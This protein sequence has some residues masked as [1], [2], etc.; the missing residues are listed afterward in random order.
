MKYK[1]FVLKNSQGMELE[2]S[3]LGGIA[4]SLTAPDRDGVFEN[5]L[6]GF[7]DPTLCKAYGHVSTLVGRVCNRIRKGR[8]T[9][10]GKTYQLALNTES[11]GIK[12]SLHGGAIGFG[13]KV[14]DVRRFDSKD[15]PALEMTLLSPDGDEGYP[16][17]LFVRVVYTL[18]DCNAWRIEYWAMTD[19]PTVFNPTHHAYFN[20]N[21]AHYD[22]LD[23]LV[24]IHADYYTPSDKGLIST[25]EVLPV[26]GTP[27]D[28]REPKR[29]GEDVDS[30]A[31]VIQ[32]A[33]GGYDHNFVVNRTGPG[34]ALCAVVEDQESGRQMETWSTEPCVQFYTANHIQPGT[35]G[36]GGLVY[37]P[38]H[39][40]CL[41]TQH[42]PDSPNQPGFESIR[43]NPGQV[44]QS[45]T[46]YQFYTI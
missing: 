37:G 46:L 44:F 12:S 34:L 36:R 22:V 27:I 2:V 18:M 4:M 5:I 21:G 20:L 41:E 28:F 14:W 24:Q 13:Q 30:R 17:N 38:R 3:N 39:G 35:L 6:L 10:D 32:R 42:A 43:L 11:G 9:L 33:G 29:I 8:F 23:H 19:A 26:D 45:T 1:L 16:G 31:A 40:F 7:D 25:G 15:G